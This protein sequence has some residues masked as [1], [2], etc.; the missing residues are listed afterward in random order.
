MMTQ[1][2]NCARNRVETNNS[3]EEPHLNMHKIMRTSD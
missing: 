2:N 1:V 3:N